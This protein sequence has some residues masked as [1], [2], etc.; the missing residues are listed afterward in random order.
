MIKCKYAYIA[1]VL[2][3]SSFISS[4]MVIT[5]FNIANLDEMVKTV[6]IGMTKKE[7]EEKMSK[8]YYVAFISKT[9]EGM[10]EVI[11]FQGY[12][13]YE[14]QFT[15]LDNKLIKLERMVYVPFKMSN[16]KN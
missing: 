3:I 8:K 9:E 6:E 16:E 5:N 2:L 7:V 1:F 11:A 13:N 14:Y 15:F 12:K 4:C 10:V